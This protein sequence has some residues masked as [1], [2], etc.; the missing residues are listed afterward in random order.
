MQR[1]K[2]HHTGDG[3][4]PPSDDNTID[5]LP[6]VRAMVGLGVST[7]YREMS[8]GRFPRP[9]NLTTRAVGWRRADILRWLEHRAQGT[10]R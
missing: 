7:I 4:F 9:I 6:A 5:R 8:F 2:H 1:I 3:V 10:A